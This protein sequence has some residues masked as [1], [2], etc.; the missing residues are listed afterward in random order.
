MEREDEADL[1]A[2]EE[3]PRDLPDAL[4]DDLLVPLF[5]EAIHVLRINVCLYAERLYH[6]IALI[7]NMLE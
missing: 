1:E 5:D 2:D 7:P 6:F 4:E 3:P